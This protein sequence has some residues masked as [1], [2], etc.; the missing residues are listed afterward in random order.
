MEDYILKLIKK[1]LKIVIS[2]DNGAMILG[3]TGKI[4][5][6]GNGMVQQKIEMRFFEHVVPEAKR[7]F[8]REK[9]NLIA[10]H[11]NF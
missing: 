2:I 3:I 7:A 6:G 1:G 5:G 4:A 9:Y 10:I 11:F 8:F